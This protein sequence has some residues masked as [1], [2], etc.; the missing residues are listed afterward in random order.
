MQVILYDISQM[1]FNKNIIIDADN[2]KCDKY[3]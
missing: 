1:I 3:A 2:Y